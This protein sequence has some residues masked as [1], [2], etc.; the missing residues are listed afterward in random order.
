M[1]VTNIARKLVAL[2]FKLSRMTLKYFIIIDVET[3]GLPFDW[4][5]PA[6]DVENWPE[7]IEIAWQLYDERREL[8]NA[9]SLLVKPKKRK[10]PLEIENLT[11]ITTA[12]A[13]SEGVELVLALKRF[14]SILQ[15]YTRVFIKFI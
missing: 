6:E 14:I 4:N 3:L 10:I 12:L 2:S 13:N 1:I 15:R 7:I 8:L 5:A 9:D 11:G